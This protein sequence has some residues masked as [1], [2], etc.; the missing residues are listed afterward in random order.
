MSLRVPSWIAESSITFTS[1]KPLDSSSATSA[2]EVE[3]IIHLLLSFTKASKLSLLQ[4]IINFF[5]QKE[6]YPRRYSNLHLGIVIQPLDAGM[7]PILDRTD[8][9]TL[10]HLILEASIPRIDLES[11]SLQGWTYN[12]IAS[13]TQ[14]VSKKKLSSLK[15]NG[16]LLRSTQL[17]ERYGRTHLVFWHYLELP[18]GSKIG[19][20]D[21]KANH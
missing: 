11:S 13:S 16:M 3:T 9:S 20:Q 12:S 5:R 8:C 18:A 19:T 17:S 14:S 10:V 15:E 1:T 21:S 7:F 2:I 6:V 4:R